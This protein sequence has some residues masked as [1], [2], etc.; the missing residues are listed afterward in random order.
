MNSTGVSSAVS[1]LRKRVCANRVEVGIRV[2]PKP[3]DGERKLKN[4]RRPV[5]PQREFFSWRGLMAEVAAS[6]RLGMLG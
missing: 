5:Q 3:L 6:I 4:S 2:G 1:L